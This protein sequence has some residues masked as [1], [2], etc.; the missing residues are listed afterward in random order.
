MIALNIACWYREE[1]LELFLSSSGGHSLKFKSKR[2]NMIE[3][4]AFPLDKVLKDLKIQRVEWV[5]IDVEGSLN[6]L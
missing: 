1:R 4:Q 3:V 5:K 6:H 2:K